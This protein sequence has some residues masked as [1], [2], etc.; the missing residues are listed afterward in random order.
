MY[1]METFW[2]ANICHPSLIGLSIKWLSGPLQR[3]VRG[4]ELHEGPLDTDG[5][6]ISL[7]VHDQLIEMLKFKISQLPWWGIT[8][9]AFNTNAAF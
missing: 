1:R 2:K 4:P 5:R 7:G 3:A 9:H 6:I 8:C